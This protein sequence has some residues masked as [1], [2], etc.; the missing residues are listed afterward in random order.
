MAPL[1]MM[2]DFRLLPA[3]R[4][5]QAIIDNDIQMLEW[6]VKNKKIDDLRNQAADDNGWSS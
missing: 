6:L 1:V 5:H 2:T 3:Q 4:F